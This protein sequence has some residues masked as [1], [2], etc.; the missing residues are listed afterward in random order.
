MLQSGSK[1]LSKCYIYL[2]QLNHGWKIKKKNKR[3][4][5]LANILPKI[6]ALT[7][8]GSIIWLNFGGCL[9]WVSYQGFWLFFLS[10]F[11]FLLFFLSFSTLRCLGPTLHQGRVVLPHFP[12]NYQ[13]WNLVGYS[14]SDCI[15][16]EQ[17]FGMCST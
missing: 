16:T 6:Q 11:S 15:A 12:L 14:A 2:K 10:F 4:K 8:C 1:Y 17:C 3:M 9:H 7:H 5:L 13:S